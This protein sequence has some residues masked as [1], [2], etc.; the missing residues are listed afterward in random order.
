M[1]CDRCHN[2][3][4]CIHIRGIDPQ[5]NVH[6]L[7]FCASCAF[8]E[9]LDE[10]ANPSELS[11]AFRLASLPNPLDLQKILSEL[12]KKVENSSSPADSSDEKMESCPDCG[13]TKHDFRQ[14]MLFGCPGCLEAF[15]KEVSAYLKL[16]ED[17]SFE[18]IEN[19]VGGNPSRFPVGTGQSAFRSLSARLQAAVQA[20]EYELA[21]SLKQELEC[22]QQEI[23]NPQ[24][25][26]S[27]CAWGSVPVVDEFAAPEQVLP[28]LPWLPK[29]KTGNPLIRISSLLFFSRN[30]GSFALPPFA[31]HLEQSEEVCGLLSPFLQKEPLFGRVREYNPQAMGKKERLELTERGWCPHEFVFRSHASRV[32]VS[33]NER[34]V[35]LLN[36]IDHLRLNLW[37]DCDDLPAMLKQ[38]TLFAEHLKA[39]FSLQYDRHFGVVSRHL[40]SLG[41]GLG[42]AELLHL[43]ALHFT[44][45]IDPVMQACAEL[46]FPLRPLFKQN[47][48]SGG[49]FYILQTPHGFF[50]PDQ[51]VETLMELSRNV[52]GHE[53]QCRQKM[54]SDNDWRLRFCDA[55]GRAVGNLKGMYLLGFVEAQHL[56]SILWLGLE[57]NMLPWLSLEQILQKITELLTL[58]VQL[59]G[60]Q[61]LQKEQTR[62]RRQLAEKFR[63]DLLHLEDQN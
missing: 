52:A 44:G 50:V 55:I 34:V 18:T 56:L 51:Q 9:F 58:P 16:P 43:P 42:M 28:N 25:E 60:S 17:F 15:K 49:A 12:I 47:E 48:F 22:L 41:T 21:A 45:Q 59:E 7:N 13:L 19:S 63:R 27:G 39:Q 23:A 5:G 33:E 24:K 57:F 8:R 11:E 6:S 62:M 3:E 2:E 31:N 1:L 54:Q 38:G 40:N 30:L 35:G 29:H 36:N 53:V 26:E 32:F 61:N 4:A 14:T 46:N 37:G 10:Q 20:E